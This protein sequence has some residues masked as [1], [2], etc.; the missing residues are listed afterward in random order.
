MSNKSKEINKEMTVWGVSFQMLLFLIP[1]IILFVFI[2][3]YFYPAFL[4]PINGIIMI[5]IGLCLIIIG[6]IIYFK[7]LFVINKAYN[8][9]KLVTTGTF[10]YVRHPLYSGFILFIIPGIVCLFNSWILFFIPLFYYIIFKIMIKK[11][12][13]Y[14]IKKFGEEY[15]DYKMRVNAIFPKI[16]K[17]NK[18]TMIKESVDYGNW[19][20][21]N[22]LYPILVIM[23]VLFII[24]IFPLFLIVRI[25]LWVLTAIFFLA[26]LYLFYLYYQFSKN[27]KELQY[28]I[29]DLVIEKLLWN[30]IGKALD[31]GTGNGAL[32]IRL[33]KNHPESKLYGIDYWGKGWNY[34][35]LI[36]ERNAKIEGVA[37]DIIFQKASASNLPFND[38]EFDAIVSNFVF[39]EVRD[40]K[41]KTKVLKESFRVLKKG[42]VFALQ[43]TFKNKKKFGTFDS[44]IKKIKN[45]NVQEINFENLIEKIEIPKLIKS[46]FNKAVVLY[47]IK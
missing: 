5:I 42:G 46:E 10:A 17:Y 19:V 3:F 31:I 11:E 45:W 2:H 35:K 8:S 16:K 24:S 39:H 4:L 9:G 43:D 25:I 1:F 7:T 32:A 40:I 13:D 38:G 29:W 26:F 33:A 20:P 21:R 14:C 22:L 41:D 27:D 6:L 23:L 34:S 36:C 47:G 28:K 30:G 37:G 18:H 44:L 15:I 12:E